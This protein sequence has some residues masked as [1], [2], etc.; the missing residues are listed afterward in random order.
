[1]AGKSLDQRSIFG[2][3][4]KGKD[5]ILSHPVITKSD[6]KSRS[7]FPVLSR[8]FRAFVAL[9]IIYLF[10]T[11]FWRYNTKWS[12]AST[13]PVE[14][15]VRPNHPILNGKAAEEKFLAIPTGEKALE[16]SRKYATLSHV[17]GS[18][19]DLKTAKIV[20]NHFYDSFGIKAPTT[21]ESFIYPAGSSQSRSATLNIK[22]TK[23][24][25]AWIDEYY[26][27]MNLPKDRSLEILDESGAVIWT[28][29]IEEDGDPLD[30]D[31]ARARTDVPVFHGLSKE[32]DV[33]GKLIYANYGRQEDLDEIE[34][35][36]GSFTGKIV[37][38][39]YEKLFRGLKVK[40]AAERGAIGV[41]IYSDPRDDTGITVE[42]GF[43]PYPHGPARNPTSVQ[44]GSVQYLSLYPGDP[45][46]P[47]YPA[48]ANS[49]RVEGGNIPSIPSLPISWNNAQVLLKEIEKGEGAGSIRLV[50][51]V[52]TK[53]TPIWNTMAVIPGH[54]K[55]EVVVLG[56]HRDAWVLGAADPSS[57]SSSIHEVIR[58]FGLLHKQGWKPLRTILIASWDAEEYGLIGSTEHGE[59]FAEWISEN[60]VAYVNLVGLDSSVS[61]SR[62]TTS[63]SPSLAHLIRQVALDIPHPTREN[64]T[65]WDALSDRGQYYVPGMV[66]GEEDDFV[67]K[68]TSA[69]SPL[70]SGSDYTVY[71]QRLGVASGQGGFS[72]TAGDAV[73]HYHS[74][75]DSIRSQELY[76]DPGYHRHAAIAKFVGLI[77][78]RLADSII[79]PL[80]T[81]YYALELGNYIDKVAKAADDLRVSIDLTPLRKSVKK[82][83][84]AS[85]KLDKEKEDAEKQLWRIIRRWQRRHRKQY[86]GI[87]E[88][89]EGGA[90]AT[91]ENEERGYKSRWRRL[92]CFVKNLLG[93][94]RYDNNTSSEDANDTTMQDEQQDRIQTSNPRHRVPRRLRRAI[95]RV[96]NANKKLSTF[97][98][99]FISKDGIKDREWYKHLGVAPGKWLGYGST[100]LPALTESIT[101]EKN[102]TLAEYEVGRLVK[103]IDQLTEHLDV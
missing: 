92:R 6:H 38:V 67:S 21:Q 37:L 98:A 24:P 25:R 27:V 59:D 93:L 46:T 69:V 90:H 33:T 44:R 84:D 62:F 103:L 72:R 20:F 63:A 17:A 36:G 56:N 49:T 99:G 75:Y 28:A 23:T 91:N 32:G 5:E 71:L 55:D 78:L 13:W 100:T 12:P 65:V 31:A 73:Y 14:A 53:I 42:N 97:E 102:K 76:A 58:A 26:P 101:I 29:D 3:D 80:N 43:E 81:T 94:R 22:A 52:D 50:N 19:Q 70:G 88:Q 60:V 39:R 1:M 4:R 45:T 66:S 35:A 48:Y 51:Q 64:S 54:I 95:K 34:S 86:A 77:T 7:T 85:L 9:G 10:N 41:L 30:E 83:Q 11:W 68:N 47:G 18:E 2:E 82:L 96:Q 79:L 89:S 57:G 61:G 87:D 40:G 74:I 15:F 16:A 8:F